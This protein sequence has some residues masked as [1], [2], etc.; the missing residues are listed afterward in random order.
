MEGIRHYLSVLINRVYI[1]SF[2]H[3]SL[4]LG[5][6]SITIEKGVTNFRKFLLSDHK[7]F[8]Q[9]EILPK[10]KKSKVVNLVNARITPG[11]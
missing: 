6:I 9:Y 11:H 1:F 7:T 4:D 2:S 10:T 5:K 8:G 3:C